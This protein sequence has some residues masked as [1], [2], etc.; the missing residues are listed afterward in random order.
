M[1]KSFLLLVVACFWLAGAFAQTGSIENLQVAQRTDGSGL[2]DIHFDLNGAGESYNLQFEASFDDGASYAPLSET[3]LTGELTNV[4]PG[5]GKHIIWAGKASHPETF[6]T[7]TRV[8]VI[9]IEYIPPTAPT[10]ITA[11]ITNIT[12]TSSTSGGN[13]TDDGG[14]PVI[15]RGVVWST[16]QNP[17]LEDYEGFTEDGLGEG[18]FTSELTE[19][20]PETTYYSRAYAE[21]SVGIGY[22]EE[23]SFE[24]LPIPEWQ[25][26]DILIDSR[27][28]NEYFTVQ[29][30]DQCWMAENL[31]FLPAVS[32]NTQGS[33]I[34]PYYYVYGYNGTN[35]SHAKSNPNYE[36][37]G[38]LYNWPAALISCPQFWFLPEDSDWKILEGA[39]DS[40]YPIGDPEWDKAGYWRGYDVSKN[41]KSTSLWDNNG[42]GIDLF[43][44]NGLP[45]GRRTY[46]N[47]FTYKD[48]YAFWWTAT[49]LHTNPNYGRD[50]I[51]VSEW[52]T[53]MRTHD[54]KNYGYS[55]RCLRHETAPPS[56]YNLNLEVN[57]VGAGTV[58]GDGQYQAGQQVNIS[59]E[60]NSGWEFVNWTEYN[61]V[62]S[63]SPNFVY[64]MPA[65]D[66]TLTAI[67][68]EEVVGFTCGDPLIDAR[69]G[70]S[71][72][73]VQI[74]TQCWMA[75]NLAF[76]PEVTQSTTV[77]NYEP[78][79]YVYGYQG[80]NITEAK[81]TENYQTYGVLYNW[82]AAISACPNGWDLPT[83]NETKIL[84]G[85][86]DSQ[87]EVSN[88]IWDNIQWRGFDVGKNLK[89]SY[90]WYGIQGIDLINFSGLPGGY[91][92]EKM[93]EHITYIGY[94]WTASETLS[95]HATFRS[96]AY[97]D[98]RSYRNDEKKS[99]GC[100]I[101]CIKK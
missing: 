11:E 25:C 91:Q 18:E 84:E 59:T 93:F 85:E 87:Y 32:Q 45:G 48:V 81:A 92:H 29:I 70:Q 44:F 52:N 56:N 64:T 37:Y 47:G 54:E 80:F 41:L 1:K 75:E 97:Y 83:D 82:T 53:S 101:R 2:V 31:A 49:Q 28:G 57:P 90:G 20:L 33:D 30:G 58:T 72:E 65:Q 23:L 6:S 10:V 8:R 43:G 15:A 66:I 88:Q 74:G 40:Q 71:Y 94:W 4:L 24:T 73:T 21:N 9:A 95:S 69:D 22:G 14:A 19:L 17:T 78:Y 63:E 39:A 42:N 68:V 55:V 12:S 77:S 86:S 62:V 27:D 99:T 79:Y 7:Q 51:F 46:A 13:V 60:A 5:A 34:D 50:R 96:L 100:S 3:F 35:I 36:L 16:S 76:L 67:F 98:D 26:G 38:V 89:T 61:E